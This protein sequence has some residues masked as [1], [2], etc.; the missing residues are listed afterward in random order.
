MSIINKY[1]RALLTAAAVVAA[2][3]SG[4]FAQVD[5]AAV[6]FNV[7]VDATINA[8][9]KEGAIQHAPITKTAA[10]G[11]DVVVKFPLQK[12]ATGILYAGRN[13]QNVP[14]ISAGR[15]GKISLRLPAQSYNNA[16]I[17]LFSVNGK[18]VM[19]GKASAFDG[20]NSISRRNL[21]AGV[22]LLSI[23]VD[24]GASFASRLTHNGGSLNIDAA[25]GVENLPSTSALAKQAAS[26]DWTVT[27]SASGYGDSTYTLNPESGAVAKQVITLRAEAPDTGTPVVTLLGG[28]TAEIRVGSTYQDFGVTVTVNGLN[29]PTALDSVVVKGT[30]PAS[31]TYRLKV[32]K[33][34]GVFTG[35]V[36]PATLA[37]NS[38]FSITYYASYK[39][40]SMTVAK[41][42]NKVRTVTVL[43][44][45]QRNVTPVIVLSGYK[46]KLK[47]GTVIDGYPDTMLYIGSTDANYVE[48]GV[49][50]VYY[51]RDGAE[52]AV[53]KNL[54]TP[55]RPSSFITGQNYAG[56]KT[57]YYDISA[58][59]GYAAA[60]AKRNVYLVDNECDEG[61]I[62]P[63]VNVSGTDEIPA[64]TAWDYSSSWSVINQ[65][66][67]G[68]GSGGFK[69]FI[70]F[71][72][73]NPNNPKAGTYKI[74]YVGLGRCGGMT[75]LERTITVK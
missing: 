65:D 60:N 19:Q 50:K 64:G 37:A 40:A 36:L 46:H 15:G 75:E 51:V 7:N 53:D 74:T 67:L 10:A 68:K 12:S 33:P 48:K 49:D 23:K 9:L 28:A 58:G 41:T 61:K 14:I 34:N 21:T 47:N 18:R 25:F 66:E 13:H 39:G 31:N 6:T 3:T 30:S 44:E 27:V 29:T 59:S 16:E 70:H 56:A 63:T 55:T 71:N 42:D 2:F 38:T 43:P 24:D 8:A 5:T 35:V 11:Q 57:V 62:E 45:V 22:Y 73:L 69:Y 54:V 52:V 1:G 26:G 17:A 32:E 4:V 20:I 72:G